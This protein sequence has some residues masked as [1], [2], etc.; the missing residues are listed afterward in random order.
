MSTKRFINTDNMKD[1]ILDLLQKEFLTKQFYGEKIEVKVDLKDIVEQKMKDKELKEPIVYITVNAYQKILTLV[2]E[3]STEV[4]WHCLVEHPAGTDAYLIYD[5]LVFPQEVTSTTTNGTDG[6]YEMW[7][8]TLPDDQF[9]KCRCHMHSHVNMGT[10]PS[11]TDENYYSN[12]M[13]QVTDFYITMIINKKGEYHL[14]FYD[15][16]NN[17]VYMDM[18]LIVC[19]EDG[20]PLITWFN[21][22][23]DVV[24]EKKYVSSYLSSKN[25]DGNW[26]GRQGSFYDDYD[27]SG[28]YSKKK[29]TTTT[30]KRGRGRPPKKEEEIKK[31]KEVRIQ[32]PRNDLHTFVSIDWAVNYIY[33]QYPTINHRFSK[34]DM[35]KHLAKNGAIAYDPT[36]KNFVYDFLEKKGELEYVIL[37]CELWEVL[38][39]ESE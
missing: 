26:L 31:A 36:I 1:E 18:E 2:K 35:R 20:T 14:R 32:G 27:Y 6:E 17:I 4:S 39:D 34:N 38:K 37:N 21:S 15:K 22:V 16:E 11:G 28:Y 8:A 5:V 13:T 10:T 19:F 23:K 25:K 29:E 33:N 30:K 7:L 24:K 9:N 12:L 3:F